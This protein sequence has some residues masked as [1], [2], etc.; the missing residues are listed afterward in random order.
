MDARTLSGG[1]RRIARLSLLAAL[2]GVLTSGSLVARAQDEPPAP[3]TEAVGY[4]PEADAFGPGWKRFEPVAVPNLTVDTFREGALVVYGGP[5]GSRV[6]LWAL[7]VDEGRVRRAWED[8]TVFY[9]NVRYNLVYDYEREEQLRNVP[10]PPGCAEAKRLDGRSYF[11]GFEMGVTLC[12]ADPDL[13]LLA[14]ASGRVDDETGFAGS[15]NVVVA[16]LAAGASAGSD[17]GTATATAGG[18]I[19]LEAFDIGWSDAVLRAAPG[20]TVLVT[21]TGVTDHTFVVEDLGIDVEIVP[22]ESAEASIPA[23]AANGS[24]AFVCEI[25]GHEAAGMVGEL[26]IEAAP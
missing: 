17:D 11:D 23:D 24:Y 10:P 14:V 3:G 13:I 19:A 1:I 26:V 7:L 22:G 25:P 5:E 4:L 12:A 21:N 20:D 9:D 16:A 6:M 18:T 15:D 8:A 2:L